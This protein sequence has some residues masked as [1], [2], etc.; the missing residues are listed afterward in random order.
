MTFWHWL[1][2]LVVISISKFLCLSSLLIGFANT[3]AVLISGAD[4]K[5][6]GT[7][8]YTAGTLAAIILQSIAAITLSAL[9]I[10]YARYI[11]SDTRN[12]VVLIV[13]T[14]IAIYPMWETVSLARM[15]RVNE[16]ESYV[17]KEVSHKAVPY[18]FLIIVVFTLLFVFQPSILDTLFY[19][20]I[21]LAAFVGIA[22]VISVVIIA[23]RGLGAG[24]PI[25]NIETEQIKDELPADST[26]E[27][28]RDIAWI[29]VLGHVCR[30]L[31]FDRAGTAIGAGNSVKAKSISK[32][33]GY[34]L[35]E[36]PNFVEPFRLPITHREDFLLAAS[37]FDNPDLVDLINQE[38]ML[39]TYVPEQHLPTGH[40]LSIMHALHYVIVPCETLDSY[41]E[42]NG[43]EHTDTSNLE[44]LF[45]KFVYNGEIKVQVNP[46]PEV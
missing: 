21:G 5:Y 25:P 7:S 26:P 9:I 18:S 28:G 41:Y 36:S 6:R 14:V 13:T 3:P 37:V 12:I 35:V 42:I 40:S 15:E 44:R 2:L 23:R 32:P 11:T 34:L 30:V 10:S 43:D 20:L 4:I 24:S 27:V 16:P 19:W 38:E 45:G 29:D 33:Y 22:S 39:V 1:I 31:D 17:L 46:E 8:R